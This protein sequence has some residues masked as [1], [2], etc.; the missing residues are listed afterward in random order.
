MRP[1]SRI[2]FTFLLLGL[3]KAGAISIQF[4]YTYDTGNFFSGAN[5]G[6]RSYLDA[7]AQAFTLELSDSLSAIVPYGNNTWS[8][9]FSDP[10]TGNTISLSNLQIQANTLVVYVGARNLGGSTLGIGGPG[11]YSISGSQQSWFDTV[12]A[13]GQ[14]GALASTPTDFGPWGGSIVFN[15]T[16]PWYFDSDPSTMESFF[17][18]D[19]FYSVALHELA[20]TLG[21]G[22]A[23]SWMADVSGTTFTGA[24][25][26]LVYGGLHPSVSADQ[27]H[28]A[29]GTSSKIFGTNT[30]QETDMDPAITVGT[31][32]YL[33]SL[34]YAGLQDVGWTTVPE[35]SSYL[36]LL[37]GIA[38]LG[39][40]KRPR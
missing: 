28:W 12:E 22:T 3:C 11:G 20:H 36:L 38:A 10:S 6:R 31:R 23:P 14:T 15:S 37:L 30:V 39:L 25:S 5:I 13:R 16:S 34:D 29:D 17:G 8:A 19:D 26:T 1:F 24:A 32:K 27:G 4:D 7:A 35:P 18:Q 9:S 33:T 40:R 21:F 2:L